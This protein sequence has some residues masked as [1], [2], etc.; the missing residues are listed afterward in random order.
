MHI[1][2]V[3]P[4]AACIA[5]IYIMHVLLAISYTCPGQSVYFCKFNTWALVGII[6]RGSGAL[7]HVMMAS[8]KFFVL[9]IVSLLVQCRAENSSGIV[10]KIVNTVLDLT[11]HLAKFTVSVTLENNGEKSAIHVL[12]L[13]DPMLVDNLAYINA[14]VSNMFAGSNYVTCTVYRLKE[15]S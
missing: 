5:G 7:L 9:I 8:S 10:N 13:I 3:L 1:A 12:Y 14:E 15:I 4:A 6:P 2:I 11:S